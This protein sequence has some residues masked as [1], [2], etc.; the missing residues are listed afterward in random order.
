M[1]FEYIWSLNIYGHQ[2]MLVSLVNVLIIIYQNIIYGKF[3]T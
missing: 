2:T 3:I 1:L